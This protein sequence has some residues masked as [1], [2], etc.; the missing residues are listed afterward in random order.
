MPRSLVA[1]FLWAY[2]SLFHFLWSV[3]S[4]AY[5]GKILFL[6]IIL[7]SKEAF[8]QLFCLYL[9]S[10]I[11][12][13]HMSMWKNMNTYNLDKCRPIF[14]FQIISESFKFIRLKWIKVLTPF[15]IQATIFALIFLC[16]LL[17]E[18]AEKHT[19]ISLWE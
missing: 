17:Y 1:Q 5:T 13:L 19:W 3:S 10:L 14:I 6:Q 4:F 11:V 7:K 18:K 2:A 9:Y 8:V 16:L 15:W 12:I